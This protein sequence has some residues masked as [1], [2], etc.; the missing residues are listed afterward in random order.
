MSMIRERQV[1]GGNGQNFFRPKY[2]DMLWIEGLF[3]TVIIF[4]SGQIAFIIKLYLKL[5]LR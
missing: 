2:I 4:S 5:L 1:T 3:G